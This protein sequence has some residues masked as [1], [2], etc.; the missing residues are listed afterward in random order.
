M[1]K[2]EMCGSA[3]PTSEMKCPDCGGLISDDDEGPNRKI[4]NSE[5]GAIHISAIENET[6]Q[7][8]K[9]F[10]C[11]EN[12]ERNSAQGLFPGQLKQI[13][14]HSDHIILYGPRESYSILKK[15]LQSNSNSGP[16]LTFHPMQHEKIYQ[17]RDKEQKTNELK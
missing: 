3:I 4:G 5:W 12:L 8:E 10:T 2:C 16:T 9:L 15:A 6:Y 11:W 13:E 1:K 7:W 17:L 14:K